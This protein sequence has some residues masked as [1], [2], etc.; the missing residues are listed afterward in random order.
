MDESI[1]NLGR[2]FF[3]NF[4][5]ELIYCI[6]FNFFIIARH[7]YSTRQRKADCIHPKVHKQRL[8]TE[9]QDTEEYNCI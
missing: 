1:Y 4:L 9:M 3:F 8:C 6:G 5:N 7:M 2:C